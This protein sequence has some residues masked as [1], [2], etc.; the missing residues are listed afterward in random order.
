[1]KN[2]EKVAFDSA[3]LEAIAAGILAEAKQQGASQAEVGIAIDKGFTVT[4]READVETVEYNQD[5]VVDIKVYFDKRSG[6]ASLSD[7][8][9]EAIKAAVEAACHIAKFTGEDPASGLADKEDLATHYPQLDLAYPWPISVEKAIELACQCEREAL[10][11]DKRIMSA[12]E[13]TVATVDAWTLY[14]NS[15]GLIGSFPYT[16]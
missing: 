2:I 9:P 4:A 6:S 5:K 14:A 15:N 7:L 16:R 3:K 1:M 10:A 13:A 11:Y 12:E 8:R